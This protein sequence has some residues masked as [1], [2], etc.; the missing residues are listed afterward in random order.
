LTVIVSSVSVG[1][2][3]DR[4]KEKEWSISYYLFLFNTLIGAKKNAFMNEVSSAQE[5]S[6]GQ[7]PTEEAVRKSATVR[8]KSTR[9]ES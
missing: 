4:D 3:R 1:D 9:S 7:G 2:T 8:V 6:L 5:T